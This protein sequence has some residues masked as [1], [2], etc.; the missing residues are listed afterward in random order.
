MVPSWFI[1]LT[2][3]WKRMQN[4]AF[5]SPTQVAL[6]TETAVKWTTLLLFFFFSK[7][8]KSKYKFLTPNVQSLFHSISLL[9]LF[10]LAG[11]L[12]FGRLRGIYGH[13]GPGRPQP[14]DCSAPEVNKAASFCLACFR[15]RKHHQPA[16]QLYLTPET[17]KATFGWSH[18]G[19]FTSRHEK[20]YT[21]KCYEISI[22]FSLIFTAINHSNRLKGLNR[23]Y[24][25]D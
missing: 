21:D 18:L 10:V 19:L 12:Q 8:L 2:E 16:T 17:L 3:W 11:Q 24:I 7:T 9:R 13:Q 4:S 20:A 22:E 25:Y 6:R 14:G 23:L 5:C 15:T 1:K